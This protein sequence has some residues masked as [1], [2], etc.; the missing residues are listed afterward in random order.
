M[1]GHKFR[2][3]KIPVVLAHDDI[4]RRLSEVETKNPSSKQARVPGNG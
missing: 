3:L 1:K 2:G 4:Y